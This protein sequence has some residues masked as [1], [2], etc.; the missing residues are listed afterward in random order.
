MIWAGISF[1][2]KTPAMQG[3]LTARKYYDDVLQPVVLPPVNDNMGLNLNARWDNKP[4]IQL[5]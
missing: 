2:H 1:P 5:E 4:A 3:T